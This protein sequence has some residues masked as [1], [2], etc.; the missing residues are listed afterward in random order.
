[1]KAL[2]LFAGTGWA[3]GARSLGIEEYAVEIMPE[4]NATRAANGM[5]A[6]VFEDVWS[7]QIGRAHV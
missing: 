3:V 5:S 2:D 1:M 6:P 7:G 4:A